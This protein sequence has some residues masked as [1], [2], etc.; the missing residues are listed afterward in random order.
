MIG[1]RY[2]ERQEIE[3]QEIEWQEI[4]RQEIERQEIE[5]QEIPALRE[6]PTDTYPLTV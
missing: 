3:R 5:R 2:N 4:E 1:G 6:W